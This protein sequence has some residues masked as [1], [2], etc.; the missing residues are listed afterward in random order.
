MDLLNEDDMK[1]AEGYS[2]DLPMN[3]DDDEASPE[4]SDRTAYEMLSLFEESDMVNCA[5]CGKDRLLDRENE[6]GVIGYMLGCYQ[7]VC[8]GCI[9]EFK[10]RVEKIIE[11][12]T[13]TCPFCDVDSLLP[14]YFELTEAAFEKAKLRAE[15]LKKKPRQKVIS[16]YNGPSTKTSALI[17]ALEEA[18]LR[19]SDNP[20]LPKNKSVV[21][22]CWTSYLDLIEIALEEA[23]L[24]FK[25]VRLDGKMSREKRK[26][27]L[28]AFKDDPEVTVLLASIGAGGLGLNLTS[29]NAVYIMEPQW[30]PA[31][32]AQA[33]D[34][35]HR[36]GQKRDVTTVRFII[37]GTVENGMREMQQKKLDLAD[38]SM[39]KKKMDKKETAKE[40]LEKLASLFK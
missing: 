5:N 2:D 35:V 18:R 6:N 29:A 25:Y 16:R 1:L 17:W 20:K 32:E 30:N 36:L 15:E 38:L 10:E 3:I 23:E 40:R 12:N 19:D 7:I 24:P 33:V 26:A 27:S 22:S 4:M 39:T 37:D 28:E 34:R 13:F 21:F 9:T 8:P 11:G 31:A 14:R